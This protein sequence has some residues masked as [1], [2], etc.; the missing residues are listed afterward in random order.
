M[1][2]GTGVFVFSANDVRRKSLLLRFPKD[3]GRLI[4][5]ACI[6]LFFYTCAVRKRKRQGDEVLDYLEVR[7]VSIL[8]IIALSTIN[9]KELKLEKEDAQIHRCY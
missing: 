2:S 3:K 8:Y 6:Y 9:R 5:C 4:E 1:Y 7:H